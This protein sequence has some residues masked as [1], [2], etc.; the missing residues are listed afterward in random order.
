[1]VI[2]ADKEPRS[3]QTSCS[4]SRCLGPERDTYVIHESEFEFQMRRK[5]TCL[6]SD[7][8][9]EQILQ[10]ANW[11]LIREDVYSVMIYMQ[12]ESQRPNEH[13]AFGRIF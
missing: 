7:V 12:I 10:I 13:D 9:F 11:P 2:S 6:F 3:N 8:H 4:T 1:M 5:G